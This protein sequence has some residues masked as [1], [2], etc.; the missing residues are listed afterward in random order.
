MK[1]VGRR[2]V[3]LY[4]LLA[5]FALGVGFLYFK[6]FRD[7]SRWITQ[8]YNGH[9]YAEDAVAETGSIY[10]RNDLLLAKS[11]DGSRIYSDNGDIRRALLHT[12]GDSS[13]YISTSVQSMLRSELMGYNV[14]TGLNKTPLADMG[15]NDINLTLDAEICAE[16]YNAFG[17]KNG[18]A[19]MYN[20]KTGEV[21]C[22]VSAPT[23][24]PGDVP[25][26]L[27]ENEEY[28]GV[29]VDNTISSSYTP[30][31]V[32]K[33]VTA[34]CAMENL[35]DW[36]ERTYYCDGESEFSDGTVTCLDSHGE[37]D[38]ETAMMYSC[39]SYFSEL[40]VD[41]GPAKLMKTA[42]ELGFNKNFKFHDFTTA[43][44]EISLN[45]KMKESDLGWSGIGQYTLTANPTH[46]MCL[47][48]AIANGGS[49]VEPTITGGGF[50][51]SLSTTELMSSS[52]ASEISDI[53]RTAVTDYYGDS[54]F[55]G[56]EVCAKTGTA[57]VGQGKE[58]NA[59]MIGFARNEDT[60]YAFA[61][62]VEEGGSGYDT[63]G[64][65]A[66]LMMTMARDRL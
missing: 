20:Y 33:V 11:E 36:D 10:D 32:F 29:F 42:E 53:M 44:S 66:S 54:M 52:I 41:L 12:V 5:C 14:V 27:N 56:M 18:A 59:W 40:A 21:I 2:S 57:E 23:Y 37:V 15:L 48:G 6:I 50:G 8:P 7:G 34:I 31:S 38:M 63:A 43:K 4:I 16:V 24:D 61:V 65:I 39:N 9:I 25:E 51:K 47:M 22:K 62:C 28:D 45:G 46:L 58:P 19:I 35:D 55:E 49:F 3:V 60:P 26:D 64:N 30:G 1:T 13:G 17:G